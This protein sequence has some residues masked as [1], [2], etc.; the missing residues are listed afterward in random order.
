METN[1]SGG[2][3]M[4]VVLTVLVTV[5]SLIVALISTLKADG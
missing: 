1:S 5:S 3:V 4:V 2:E